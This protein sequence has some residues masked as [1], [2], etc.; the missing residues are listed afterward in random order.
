MKPTTA[1][2]EVLAG[3]AVTINVTT[4][5]IPITLSQFDPKPDAAIL[6]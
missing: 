5:S 4:K 2:A 1:I 3:I 6:Y